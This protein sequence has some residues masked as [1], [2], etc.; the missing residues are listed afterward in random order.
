MKNF[1]YL[2][3]AL[4]IMFGIEAFPDVPPSTDAG[5]SS[6]NNTGGD[7]TPIVIRKRKT[8]DHYAP[9]KGVEIMMIHEDG[10][11][12]LVM[13]S[14]LYPA[15]VTITV[16]GTTMGCW[17]STLTDATDVMPFDEGEGDYR[18]EISTPDGSYVGYFTLE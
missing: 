18:L 4:L 13:P 17:T 12:N 11:I 5:F 6:E 9:A 16:E 3:L 2:I 8:P 14:Y 10:V 7:E 15:D 1:K